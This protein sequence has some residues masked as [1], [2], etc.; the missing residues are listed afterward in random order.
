[1][2][3]SGGKKKRK[4]AET[5]GAEKA[6]SPKKKIKIVEDNASESKISE[7]ITVEEEINDASANVKLKKKKKKIEQRVSD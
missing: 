6:G 7:T 1:M 5:E 2:V 3:G 4:K